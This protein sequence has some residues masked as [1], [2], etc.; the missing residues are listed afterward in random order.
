MGISY[1]ESYKHGI[2]VTKGQK[3]VLNEAGIS[4]HFID[5]RPYSSHLR[6]EITTS[7]CSCVDASTLVDFSLM[8]DKISQK[9][10]YDGQ[11]INVDGSL[12]AQH[13]NIGYQLSGHGRVLFPQTGQ[14]VARPATSWY[15]FAFH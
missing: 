1:S 12:L 6:C 9:M 15:I 8:G 14:C 13:L 3:S 11:E 4:T 7:E 2:E 10:R 5:A